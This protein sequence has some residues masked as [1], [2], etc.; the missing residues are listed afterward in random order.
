MICLHVVPNR[1]LEIAVGLNSTCCFYCVQDY[2]GAVAVLDQPQR[3]RKRDV[4]PSSRA[5]AR[6]YERDNTITRTLYNMN[7]IP[8]GIQT[9]LKSHLI[10]L[11]LGLLRP[12]HSMPKI[13]PP[14]VEN[15]EP[16]EITERDTAFVGI[17]KQKELALGTGIDPHAG[18]FVV[19]FDAF[20]EPISK[21]EEKH[22]KELPDVVRIQLEEWEKQMVSG[23]IRRET[24]PSYVDKNFVGKLGFIIN[25]NTR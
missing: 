10:E 15:A 4:S 6:A 11:P 16:I 8:D 13:Y 25:G 9:E 22:R 21:M 17:L 14:R 7:I 19:V 12:G 1:V 5:L 2:E 3:K 23:A 20:D 24:V 18:Y